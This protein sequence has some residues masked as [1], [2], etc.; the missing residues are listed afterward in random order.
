M[1]H[2]ISK[3]KSFYFYAIDYGY[4]SPPLTQT[5]RLIK[6]HKKIELFKEFENVDY[7]FAVN[8][9]EISNYFEKFRIMNQKQLIDNYCP[10]EFRESDNIDVKNILKFL[11]D[12]E[13]GNKFKI[14][15]ANKN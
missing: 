10:I 2:L 12:G 8:F 15:Y 13:I 14:F 6:N 7:S 4:T 11:S 1:N 9:N 3:F 5:L